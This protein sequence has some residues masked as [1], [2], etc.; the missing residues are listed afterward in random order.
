MVAWLTASRSTPS[1]RSTVTRSCAPWKTTSTTSK[2]SAA[3]GGS[4]S[5]RTRVVTF[6]SATPSPLSFSYLADKSVGQLPTL[7][8]HLGIDELVRSSIG[9]PRQPRSQPGRRGLKFSP[10]AP[11]RAVP[12]ATSR[13]AVGAPPPDSRPAAGPFAVSRADGRS[14]PGGHHG[15]AHVVERR[16]RGGGRP[17]PPRRGRRSAAGRRS[18][19]LRRTT[20]ARN[21][22]SASSVSNGVG[23]SCSQASTSVK[24]AAS[25]RRT[26]SAGVANSHGQGSSCPAGAGRRRRW[27]CCPGPRTGPPAARRGAGR[28]P[29]GRRAGRGRAPSGRWRWTRPRPPAAADRQGLG[30]IGLHELH[31][32]AEAGQPARASASIDGAASRA[33]TEMPGNRSRSC[34]VT[35]PLPQPASSTRSSPARSSRSR[36]APPHRAWGSAMRS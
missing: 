1:G 24:P 4:T 34:S 15:Q 36:T 6:G 27:R 19:W 3:R 9:R 20:V 32:V 26:V 8:H 5:S 35:R 12:G 33:T 30:Q 11:M 28:R 18:R 29:G 22:C 31:P 25:S 21:V 13:P 17:P 16:G 14:G 2:P 7:G 23:S 10:P